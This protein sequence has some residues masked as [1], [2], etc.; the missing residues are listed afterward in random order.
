[1]FHHFCL[2][3]LVADALLILLYS[4]LKVLFGCC[5]STI[6]YF[7]FK[8]DFSLLMVCQGMCRYF[9][10]TIVKIL[11]SNFRSFILW[12]LLYDH[13]SLLLFHPC[14]FSLPR[15]TSTWMFFW[16]LLYHRYFIY[17]T[18]LQLASL[19]LAHYA[20]SLL[21]VFSSFSRCFHLR[22]SV[23]SPIN[24]RAWASSKGTRC[25]SLSGSF[26]STN[27]LNSWWKPCNEWKVV[28]VNM[29]GWAGCFH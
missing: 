9:S 26:P 4:V 12:I 25:S 13:L 24:L 2:N 7:N 28:A 3:I 21:L 1:M 29:E 14:C 17:D 8:N 16:Q 18:L 27:T 22:S 20:V 5:I 6:W 23:R 19:L 11:N 10:F 15:F